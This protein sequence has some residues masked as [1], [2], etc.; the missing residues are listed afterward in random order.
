MPPGTVMAVELLKLD[1]P[2]LRGGTVQTRLRSKCSLLPTGIWS[3]DFPV[4]CG[5]RLLTGRNMR[6]LNVLDVLMTPDPPLGAGLP[7]SGELTSLQCPAHVWKT[8]RSDVAIGSVRN[9]LNVLNS[10]LNVSI[11]RK[12]MVVPTLTACRETSG[13]RTRPLTRRQMTTNISIVMVH[14][15]LWPF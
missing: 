13:E 6:L 3:A 9:V 8:V 11:E 5:T 7:T 15:Y 14:A 12:V 1:L 2:A 10:E 4:V